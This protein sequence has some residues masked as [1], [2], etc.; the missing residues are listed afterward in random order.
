MFSDQVGRSK[1][2]PDCFRCAATQL[3]LDFSEILHVGD[4]DAKDVAGAQAVGM[5]AILFTAARDEGST[6]TTRAD[7]VVSTY[8]DLIRVIDDIAMR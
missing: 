5:Q 3:D 2:N 7:A 6:E 4:R 1:P 8:A